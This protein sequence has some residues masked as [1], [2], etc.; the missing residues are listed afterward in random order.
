[1]LFQ[2]N[3]T[4]L[5]K[6]IVQFHAGELQA[7]GGSGMGL[8]STFNTHLISVYTMP[9][10]L[11]I[12]VMILISYVMSVTKG[13]V[14]LH[15][16]R[17]A[18]FS[19]GEHKGSTFTVELP[20][21]IAPVQ[22]FKLIEQSYLND[23]T[24]RW[25]NESVMEQKSRENSDP[26]R[27]FRRSRTRNILKLESSRLYRILLVD[28]TALNRKMLSRLLRPQCELIIEAG[29]GQDAVEH[30]KAHFKSDGCSI[31]AVI[32]DHQMPVMDGPTAA[33]E[34]R[35]MGYKGL[36]VGVTGNALLSDIELFLSHGADAVLNKPIDMN[37]LDE[38]LRGNIIY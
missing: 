32:M 14:D 23:S 22:A 1:M 2:E 37:K 18:V 28:D 7:G 36:I 11:F 21:A 20:T 27:P 13:I 29:D 10:V 33:K 31:D 3:Q 38:L 5:F 24:E 8:Y 25:R 30:L 15:Q 19:E 6:E 34:M 9:C 4:R 16:G 35:S 26:R 17:I 12:Q